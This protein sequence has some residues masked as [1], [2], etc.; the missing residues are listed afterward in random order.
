M[1]IQEVAQELGLDRTE[2]LFWMKEF[3][4]RP[5]RCVRRHVPWALPRQ[6]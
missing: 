1:Q 6:A 5:E 3:A 4:L 2:V